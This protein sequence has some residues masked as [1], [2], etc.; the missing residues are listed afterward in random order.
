MIVLCRVCGKEALN[1]RQSGRLC[2]DCYKDYLREYRKKNY[3]ILTQKSREKHRAKRQ[4]AT[5]V[6]SERERGRNY[7]KRLRH[8]AIMAYGGYICACCGE[9][10]PRFLTIDHI[11]NDGAA[12]RKTLKNR[13]ASIFKW[14]KD[15]GYPEGFQILCMN[16]NHGK[17]H[18]GGICPHQTTQQNRVNSGEAQ[19]G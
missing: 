11:N 16:C 3:D 18:N 17:A 5:F 4:D 7:W 12:H 13:G 6:E 19:T 1:S 15:N 2:V 9:T 14:L 10:E 8:E